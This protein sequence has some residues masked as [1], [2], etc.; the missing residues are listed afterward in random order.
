MNNINSG[1]RSGI[2]EKIQGR[3][4]KVYLLARRF[5][6]HIKD[7]KNIPRTPRCGLS[8]QETIINKH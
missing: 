1:W 2:L 5:R 3:L 4:M 7:L 8:K 6:K